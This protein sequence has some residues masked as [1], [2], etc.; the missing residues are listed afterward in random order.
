MRVSRERSDE[1]LHSWGK[2]HLVYGLGCNGERNV[3]CRGNDGSLGRD[4]AS[5]TPSGKLWGLECQG[6]NIMV[7]V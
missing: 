5:L 3:T 7:E 1:I 2:H 6:E 4:I